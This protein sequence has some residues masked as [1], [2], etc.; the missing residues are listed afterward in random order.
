[1]LANTEMRSLKKLSTIVRADLAVLL[2]M[3][4]LCLS[5]V[6][7]TSKNYIENKKITLYS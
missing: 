7:P 1:M 4:G 2:L 3:R 5:S 6:I